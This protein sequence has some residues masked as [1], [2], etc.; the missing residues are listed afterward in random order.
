MKQFFEFFSGPVVL[1]SSIVICIVLARRWKADR[2]PL[3]RKHLVPLLYWGPVFLMAAMVLHIVNNGYNILSDLIA[4][5]SRFYF[6]HY[7]LQLF[8]CVVGYQAY[9]LLKQCR[10]HARGTIRFNPPLYAAM[11][12]IVATTLPT[13]AF[14]PIGIIPAAVILINFITSLLVHRP[15]IKVSVQKEMDSGTIVLQPVKEVMAEA[16]A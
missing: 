1:L 6:Y 3:A 5:R 16:E 11:A 13:F 14:T 8:G 2:N 10:Q 4:G 9:L 15:I 12:L 7:S